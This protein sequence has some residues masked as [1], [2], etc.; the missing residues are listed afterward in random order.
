MDNY[1]ITIGR[2]LGSGGKAIG[3]MMADALGIPIYDRSLINMA[4]QESGI[5]PEVLKQHDEATS[6]GLKGMAL[7]AMAAVPFV[8]GDSFYSN[9]ISDENL[10]NI[11][12]RVIQEK[13]ESENCII[14]G[15]CADYILRHHPRLLRIFIRADLEDRI[16]FLMDREIIGREEAEKTIRRIEKKRAAYHDF[17]SETIWGDSRSYDICVNSSVL[18]KE[19][20]AEFLIRY[21][22]AALKIETG[23]K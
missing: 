23:E 16:K 14:V 12:C 5:S 6:K 13:A 10:F 7:R 9:S 19:A 8:T 11:Q 18:G 15:R 2:E 22:K 21:A 3:Q 4:A 20:T 17:Y 1:V